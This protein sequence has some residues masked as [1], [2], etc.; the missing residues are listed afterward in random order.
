MKQHTVTDQLQIMCIFS[1]LI[2]IS[3]KIQSVSLNSL[4]ITKNTV[5]IKKYLIYKLR[6]ELRLLL[7]FKILLL[8][9]TPFKLNV[10]MTPIPIE[11]II[12]ETV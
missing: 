12:L 3:V 4:S 5:D 10:T 6:I 11:N 2:L 7:N 8:F 9:L 1:L